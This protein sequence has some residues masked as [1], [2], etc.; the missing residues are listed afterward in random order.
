MVRKVIARN[1]D[2]SAMV[3]SDGKVIFESLAD[4]GI[5]KINGRQMILDKLEMVRSWMKSA[6]NIDIDASGHP[7]HHAT[8]GCTVALAERCQRE[9]IAKRVTHIQLPQPLQPSQVSQPLHS[10]LKWVNI[11]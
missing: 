11:C 7:V 1:G 2:G 9:N 5:D 10:W 4:G 8:H 3:G 6:F